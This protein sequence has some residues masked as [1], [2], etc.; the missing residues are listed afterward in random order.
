MNHAVVSKDEAIEFSVLIDERLEYFKTRYAQK[1]LDVNALLEEGV[2]VTMDRTKATRLIDNLLS[3]AIKYN[4]V[5][6]SIRV[7]LKEGRL[8]VSDSGKGIA[9]EKL[10]RIFERYQRAD[11]SVGGFGIGL[12]IVAKIV[13][14]YGFAIEV[15]SVEGEGT[16]ITLKW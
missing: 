14:E 1:K 4:R 10:G 11:T 12:N 2:V 13:D 7:E 15:D 9:K 16:V 3:N 8:S 6:G 5:G